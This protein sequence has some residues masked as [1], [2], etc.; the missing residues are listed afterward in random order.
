MKLALLKDGQT[1]DD[2]ETLD[3]LYNRNMLV[4]EG[5]NTPVP[6]KALLSGWAYGAVK[7]AV[8]TKALTLSIPK[9]A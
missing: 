4:H 2:M 8:R 1:I 5:D 6:A 3:Y 7:R 9:G